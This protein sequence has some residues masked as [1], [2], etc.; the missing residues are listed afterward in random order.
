MCFALIGLFAVDWVSV[1]VYGVCHT[2]VNI[3]RP[4]PIF[5]FQY[6]T[7][8]VETIIYLISL[9]SRHWKQTHAVKA[10]QKVSG[11]FLSAKL[12]LSTF[13]T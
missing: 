7:P 6:N 1:C 8:P 9:L 5:L 10:K 4:L 11:N 2:S 3:H 13:P 12:T